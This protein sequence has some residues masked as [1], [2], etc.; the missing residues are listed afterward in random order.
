MAHHLLRRENRNRLFAGVMRG[1]NLLSLALLTG[2][3]CSSDLCGPTRCALPPAPPVAAPAAP[4][5]P[6]VTAASSGSSDYSELDKYPPDQYELH[7]AVSAAD[8]ER[9]ALRFQNERR[10]VRLIR[11]MPNPGKGP[12]T[13]LCIFEGPEVNNDIFR[14]TRY[15]S[16]QEFESP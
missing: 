15:N 6:P 7:G 1:G 12:L 4:A 8:C 11:S 10:Q 14:D 13:Y 5:A 16:P 2:T 9:M 3:V